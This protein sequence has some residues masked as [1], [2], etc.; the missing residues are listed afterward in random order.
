ML[1][2]SPGKVS[3][4]SSK[5]IYSETV[6]DFLIAYSSKFLLHH[7]FYVTS[8]S[9]SAT[10]ESNNSGY[11]LYCMFLLL[12]YEYVMSDRKLHNR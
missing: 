12:R 5:H 7:E 9:V 11:T 6:D 8:C 1:V 3:K 10:F 2:R 4:L